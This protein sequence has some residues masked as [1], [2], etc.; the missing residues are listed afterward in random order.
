M[1][2]QAINDGPGKY[3]MARRLLKGDA[4]TAFNNAARTYSTET[5]ATFN[6]SLKALTAHVFPMKAL[7]QQKRY[8]RRF[9]KKTLKMTLQEYVSRVVELN[10]YLTELPLLWKL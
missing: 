7:Q 6:S 10:Q 3:D 1:I 5:V 8:M 9:M 4:L 2:G